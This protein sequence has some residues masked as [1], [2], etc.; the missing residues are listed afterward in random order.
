MTRVPSRTSAV[1]NNPASIFLPPTSSTTTTTTMP[2]GPEPTP[3][4][5]GPNRPDEPP[6]QPSP[7]RGDEK[8][9]RSSSSSSQQE[10]QEES[11]SL[12]DARPKVKLR[13]HILD[14]DHPG[15]ARFLGAVNA[16][17]VLREG[18]QTVLTHLYGG[19]PGSEEQKG[20][21]YV[22]P[23]TRSVTLYLED[24]AGVAYTKGSDLD[25][26]HK[27]IR[28]FVSSIVFVLPLRVVTCGF[29]PA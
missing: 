10:G 29:V 27:E 25:D 18:V 4:P 15:A 24:M 23:G 19:A 14:L 26:D 6:S 28:A 20:R 9:E 11:L 5:V 16:A 3:L 2:A 8:E 22:P 17:D 7:A 12:F 13:L 21:S 1:P